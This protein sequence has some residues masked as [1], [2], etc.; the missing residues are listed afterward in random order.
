MRFWIEWECS[1]WADDAFFSN[2]I[3][4]DVYEL[5]SKSFSLELPICEVNNTISVLN[6]LDFDLQ[7]M[8]TVAS[9]TEN[10]Q[11][12]HTIWI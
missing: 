8:A 11:N 1:G 7:E 9:L 12:Q 10:I 5:F 6:L 2:Q 4:F 3:K